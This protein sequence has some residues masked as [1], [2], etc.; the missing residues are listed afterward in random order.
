MRRRERFPLLRR[1]G[2]GVGPT[3]RTARD[4]CL[5]AAAGVAVVL[6][7]GAATPVQKGHSDAQSVAGQSK[8]HP[9]YVAPAVIE[10]PRAYVSPKACDQPQ[11]AEQDNICIERHAAEIADKWG[12]LTFRVGLASAIGLFLTLLATAGAAIAAGI[13]AGA[14]K[15]AVTKSDAILAHAEDTAKR[16]LRAYLTLDEGRLL[17]VGTGDKWYAEIKIKNAGQTPAH[18]IETSCSIRGDNYPNGRQP[19]EIPN[20][21]EGGKHIIGAAGG[22]I[23]TPNLLDKPTPEMT[24]RM[25]GG[26]AIVWVTGLITYRDI[27]GDEQWMTFRLFAGGPV[28]FDPRVAGLSPHD[29]GN[30]SS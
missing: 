17:N 10:S 14:A 24:Q 18:D 23:M 6:L 27:F 22:Y 12:R 15:S 7:L 21:T 29:F 25:M 3:G 16:Q 20:Y 13:S 26:A 11:S 28:P 9:L 5:Y 1:D 30:L 4:W 8:D 2:S 19:L